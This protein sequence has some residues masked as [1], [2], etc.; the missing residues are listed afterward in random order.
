[1]LFF[2]THILRSAVQ[3]E[4]SEAVENYE[5]ISDFINSHSKYKHKKGNID[6]VLSAEDGLSRCDRRRVAKLLCNI[7]ID[8]ITSM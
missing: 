3:K 6:W 5:K 2:L 7:G 4:V 1:M 8:Q